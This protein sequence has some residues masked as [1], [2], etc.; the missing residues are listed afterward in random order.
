MNT[1]NENG[2][3]T[4]NSDLIKKLKLPLKIQVHIQLSQLIQIKTIYH[5]IIL[6]SKDLGVWISPSAQKDEFYT[7]MGKVPTP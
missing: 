7:L 5:F 1:G 3:C 6:Y 4:Q 2:T